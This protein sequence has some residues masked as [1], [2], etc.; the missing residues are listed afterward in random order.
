[1]ELD[2]LE[3]IKSLI[4]LDKWLVQ[5]HVIFVSKMCMKRP[6]LMD[7]LADISLYR[8]I[9]NQW[10]KVIKHKWQKSSSNWS[11]VPLGWQIKDCNYSDLCQY[12]DVS[13]MTSQFHYSDVIMST[14]ASQITSLTIVY[15]T[16]QSAADQRKQQS[17]ALLAFGGEFTGDRWIPHTKG[18]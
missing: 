8:H 16:V 14:M 7:V 13:S 9:L 3:L 2:I 4:A 11:G 12:S 6:F 1:M 18:Q 5:T 15:S 10:R 17:S